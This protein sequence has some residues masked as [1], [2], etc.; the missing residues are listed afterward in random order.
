MVTFPI[1]VR[2]IQER[3]AKEILWPTVIAIPW[4]LPWHLG[5]VPLQKHF[6]FY[7]MRRKQ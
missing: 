6:Y 2:E 4:K 3:P 5:N 1:L 7:I